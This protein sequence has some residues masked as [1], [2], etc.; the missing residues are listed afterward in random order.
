MTDNIHGVVN[1]HKMLFLMKDCKKHWIYLKNIRSLRSKYQG[2]NKYAL[3][4]YYVYYPF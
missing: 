4:N 2:L 3:N 1:L